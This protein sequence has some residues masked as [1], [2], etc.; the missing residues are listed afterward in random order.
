MA[1]QGPRTYPLELFLCCGVGGPDANGRQTGLSRTAALISEFT[2]LLDHLVGGGQQRFRDGQAE[3]LGGL[4]IDD[5]LDFC[6]L[7]HC[8]SAGFSPWPRD[9]L[10]PSHP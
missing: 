2:P 6:G 7:L 4:K 1:E 10:P 3:R 5:E 9:E 8:R